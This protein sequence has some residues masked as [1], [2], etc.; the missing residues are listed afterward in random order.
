MKVISFFSVKGGTGKTT[1]NMLLTSFLGHNLRKKVLVLDF[2]RPEYNLFNTYQRE[3]EHIKESG[4]SIDMDY[5]TVEAIEDVSSGAVSALAQRISLLE[6]SF[7]YVI[8][9]FPGSFNKE[10]A[11]AQMATA[12]VIDLFVIPV[13]IDGMHI[14]SAKSLATLFREFGLKSF[15]FFNKV[16]GKDKEEIYEGLE[17]WF[18]ENNL[19]ISKHRIKNSLAMRRDSDSGAIYTRSIVSFPAK[20]IRAMNPAIMNL[21]NEVVSNVEMEKTETS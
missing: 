17:E 21:L 2:D 9:D 1:F 6:G 5:I 14:A 15:L 12:R 7:D 3:I 10:D 20:A 19:Q 18:N 4:E 13:E 11:V 8:M 16:H